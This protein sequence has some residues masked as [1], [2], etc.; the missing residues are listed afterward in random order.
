MRYLSR[1]DQ[2][3]LLDAPADARDEN[4]DQRVFHNRASVD[5]ARMTFL[6]HLGASGLEP[7]AVAQNQPPVGGA[8]PSLAE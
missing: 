5:V 2:P 4:I 3:G 7:R 6:Q 1:V 8:Q